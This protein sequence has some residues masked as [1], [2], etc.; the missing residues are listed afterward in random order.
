MMELEQK[1]V[2]RSYVTRSEV[3]VHAARFYT[4]L[5]AELVKQMHPDYSLPRVA[6][7]EST[8]QGFA[9]K[10]KDE[11][12]RDRVLTHLVDK[13]EIQVAQYR[14]P[15][16]DTEPGF[17]FRAHGSDLITFGAALYGD[18]AATSFF[19][20]IARY[21]ADRDREPLKAYGAPASLMIAARNSFQQLD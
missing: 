8:G 7:L 5:Q 14:T 12:L 20:F 2:D 17:C 4:W 13:Y 21:Q 6:V 16:F 9:I 18:Q 10:F 19:K 11:D 3:D 1:P 15:D